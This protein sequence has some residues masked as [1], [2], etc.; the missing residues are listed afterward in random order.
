MLADTRS[1]P[2]QPLL[3][4]PLRQEADEAGPLT[5]SPAGPRAPHHQGSSSSIG[6]FKGPD[7]R[8]KI[9]MQAAGSSPAQHAAQMLEAQ[10]SPTAEK[11]TRGVLAVGDMLATSVEHT[12]RALGGA[13]NQYASTLMAS[14]QPLDQPLTVSTAY[15]SRLGLVQLVTQPAAQGAQLAAQWA[16][17]SR[18]ARVFV[19]YVSLCVLVCVF[20]GEAAVWMSA[21][22]RGGL[23]GAT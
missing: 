8:S 16:G 10:Q 15:M 13:L 18:G 23:P 4:P 19:L 6:S 22:L 5:P 3:A 12:G 7:D 1:L 2:L 11:L 9:A 14:T 21:C 17:E 20:W